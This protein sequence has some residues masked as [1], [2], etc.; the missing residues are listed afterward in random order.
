VRDVAD[1]IARWLASVSSADI[2]GDVAA[3][4]A[5]RVIAALAGVPEQYSD[6]I[7]QYSSD[8]MYAQTHE[9]RPEAREPLARMAAFEGTFTEIIDQARSAPAQTSPILS[10]LLACTDATGGPITNRR[11]LT[12][13][14]KDVVTA[15]LETTVHLIANMFFE[16]LSR[17][18][19]YERLR[20]REGERAAA[21]EESLRHRSPVSFLLRRAT[22]ATKLGGVPIPAESTVIVS[23][24]SANRDRGEFSNPDAFELDRM[25]AARHL[26]FGIGMHFCV[27][28]PLARLE[29]R[30]ALDA[31]LA[32][33]PGL[34]LQPEQAYERVE[35]PIVH[36]PKRLMVN[37][38]NHVVTSPGANAQ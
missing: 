19:L 26:A 2:V 38:E 11:I 25:R 27:G 16:V 8:Y 4:L 6:A 1:D 13:F 10:A 33:V 32:H 18:G 30:S 21:I 15:G 31:V 24:A 29:A 34:S 17:P 20:E 22:V 7:K 9:G 5:A 12:H 35:I 23:L 37:I 14:S 28:A 3:P 36:G